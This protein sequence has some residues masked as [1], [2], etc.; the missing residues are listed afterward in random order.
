MNSMDINRFHRLLQEAF[1]RNEIVET[2]Y[3]VYTALR[4]IGAAG[5]SPRPTVSLTI[6]PGLRGISY[7][8]VL[9]PHIRLL[10]SD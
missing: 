8:R 4:G 7:V 1:L 6:C 5:A 3:Y 10:Y 2:V 9:N